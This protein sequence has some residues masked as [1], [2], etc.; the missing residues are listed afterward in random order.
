MKKINPLRRLGSLGAALVIVSAAALTSLAVAAAPAGAA[1]TT[2]YFTFGTPILGGWTQQAVSTAATAPATAVQGSNFTVAITPQPQAI[3]TTDSG[4]TVVSI[5]NIQTLVPVPA[6][7]T[8]VSSS[9]SGTG[10][11]SGGTSTTIPASGTF[12]VTL[13]YCTAASAACTATPTNTTASSGATSAPFPFAGSTSLPYVEISTGTASLP[14]GATVTFPTINTVMTASGAVGTVMKAEITEFDTSATITILGATAT[15]PVHG[16]PTGTTALP[17]SSLTSSSPIPAASPVALASTTIAAGVTNTVPG[18]PT[19]GTATANSN[20]TVAVTWTAP[21]SN[22]GAAISGYGVNVTG[23][24]GPASG[25]FTGTTAGATATSA[26]IGNLQPGTAYTFTVF[27]TNSVGNGGNSGSTGVTTAGGGPVTPVGTVGAL[28]LAIIA[29]A[30][31]Y[32]FQRRRMSA[33]A[34]A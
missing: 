20:G 19:I 8:Y 3:P 16:W 5:Q 4:A 12:P 1:T 17:A 31:L 18:A 28:L 13:T 25:G 14:P 11:W 27:A 32:L 22:G 26:T 6:G 34:G 30:G 24:A 33:R 2:T 9:A 23:P 7:A 10:S 15:V 21:S 29:G